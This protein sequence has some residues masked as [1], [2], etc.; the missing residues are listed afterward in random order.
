[1]DPLS[2]TGTLIAVLQITTSVI[3][4]CYDYR[5]GV[6]S[7]SRDVIRITDSLNALKDSLDALLRLVET[8]RSGEDRAR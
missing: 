4:V 1:M 2:L 3:S 8:S 6:A 5:A 7:A